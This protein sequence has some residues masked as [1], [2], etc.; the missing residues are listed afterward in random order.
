[1]NE[2]PKL[3]SRVRCHGYL[4]KE[5]DGRYIIMFKPNGEHESRRITTDYHT[6]AIAYENDK[7]IADLSEFSGQSIEKTYRK[8]V[9]QE[10][11]GVL[12]GYTKV[13]VKGRIG[14]DW[15]APPYGPEYGFCFKSD[16]VFEKV[17]VVYFKNNCKRYVP[18]QYME[19]T[20]QR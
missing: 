4:A 8:M 14:T 20:E 12:V 2:K 5:S 6:K 16:L 1:M 17:G 11:E 18:I 3:F 15:E 7:E 13:K 10:F 19:Y 9:E